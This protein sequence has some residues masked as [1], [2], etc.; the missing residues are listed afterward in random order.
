VKRE[1]SFTD[2]IFLLKNSIGEFFYKFEDFKFFNFK[3]NSTDFESNFEPVLL[4][5]KLNNVLLAAPCDV[6]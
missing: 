1:L 3:K 2:Q 4:S 6:C 5:N